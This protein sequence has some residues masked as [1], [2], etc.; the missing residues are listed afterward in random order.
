V[1]YVLP[2]ATLG[3]DAGVELRD[4]TLAEARSWACNRCG[5]CCDG[6]REHLKKDEATG[7]PL[8]V[9]ESHDRAADPARSQT[10]DPLRYAPR[11][12]GAPLLQ[13]I[14][15]LD[16]G[17]GV[18]AEFDRDIDGRP[19]TSFRCRALLDAPDGP[20]GPEAACAI[21]E[22]PAIFDTSVRGLRPFNCGSF[23]VFGT[24]VDDAIIASGVYVPAT[25]AL[26]RCTWHG[27]RV[28]GPWRD[29]EPWRTR[30]EH[31]Q[32]GEPVAPIPAIP[33]GVAA[34][35][36]QQARGHLDASGA[37]GTI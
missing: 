20:G 30:F 34:A 33:A 2:V 28:T 27:I 6:S 35:L 3:Y 15:M 21:Y 10:A 4:V 17:I 23:P 18:G 1:S 22:P 5:D 8:F 32:T 31:Q 16:G 29:S 36:M 13:P 25:G 11:L 7:L 14:V 12:D 24:V 37:S 26:P 9:W 19:H